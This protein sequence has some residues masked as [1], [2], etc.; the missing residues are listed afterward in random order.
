MV[1]LA[2]LC[3]FFE[4]WLRGAGFLWAGWADRT[5]TSLWA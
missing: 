3:C 2:I 4:V 5:E 1:G